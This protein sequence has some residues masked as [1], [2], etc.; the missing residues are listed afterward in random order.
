MLRKANKVLPLFLSILVA[1][2]VRAQAFLN[3]SFETN[4]AAACDYN[5]GNAIFNSKMANCTAYGT[6]GELDIMQTSCPYGPSQNG[7]WFVALAF[8]G[9]TDAFTMQLS[10]PLVAGTT[11]SMSFWDKGDIACCPPGMPVLIGVSTVAGAT[12]TNVYTG[13]TPTGGVWNQRCFT[14]VAPNNGQHI[15]VSTSGPSRWSH[16]DNFVLNGSCAILPVEMA[17]FTSECR[18]NATVLHWTTATE[19]N[20]NYFTVQYSTD[21]TTFRDVGKVKGAGNS[22]DSRT[23]EFTDWQPQIDYAYYRIMQTDFDKSISYSSIIGAER[24]KTIFEFYFD[25]FPNPSSDE[26]NIKSDIQNADVIILN[27]IGQVVF[28][29]KTAAQETKIDISLFDTGLYFVQLI[30]EGKTQTKKLIKN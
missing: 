12:G 21:G 18:D 27:T 17:C 19:K 7:T 15:S 5:M 22:N 9:S 2:Q 13:P 30:S 16:V 4:T 1:D 23:Y 24:C 28:E 10:A 26:I 14:F 25:V 3:G 20:N 8:P 11:Y 6:G 29:G